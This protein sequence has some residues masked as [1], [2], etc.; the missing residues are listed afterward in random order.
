MRTDAR[1]AEEV[2]GHDEIGIARKDCK[3]HSGDRHRDSQFHGPTLHTP[4]TDTAKSLTDSRSPFL[5]VAI[6]EYR[7]NALIWYWNRLIGELRQPR[8]DVFL[9]IR[10]GS[11]HKKCRCSW[12]A[13]GSLKSDASRKCTSTLKP[14]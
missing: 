8:E 10:R 3:D 12:H 13:L 11:W 1:V 2:V 14:Q 9:S 7:I 6:K 5:L 4:Q